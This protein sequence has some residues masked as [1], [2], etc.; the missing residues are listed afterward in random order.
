MTHF[1]SGNLCLLCAAGLIHGRDDTCV[2]EQA[3]TPEM[4]GESRWSLNAK[5]IVIGIG[6]Q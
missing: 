1:S 5:V 4:G 3:A 2:H 6:R